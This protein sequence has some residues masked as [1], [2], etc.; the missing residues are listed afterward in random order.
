MNMK[1][2]MAIVAGLL[3]TGCQNIQTRD[4]ANDQQQLGVGTEIKANSALDRSER[5][6]ARIS[7][8][9]HASDQMKMEIP[10]RPEVI[11]YRDWYLKHPKYLNTVTQRAT[12]YLY[13]IMDEIEKRQ[14]PMELVLLPVVESA[15]NPNARSPGNAVGLWQFLSGTGSRFGLKQDR[16][17]DGRRDIQASTSA[18]LD[19]LQII[20]KSLD[21]DWPNTIAAYNAGEKRIQQ[22]VEQ[23]KRRGKDGDFWSLNLPRQTTEYVPRMLALADIIKNADK[24]G[25]KLP[26]FPNRPHLQQIDAGGQVDLAV[27]ADMAGISL[28]EIKQF[29]PGYLRNTTSASG[30][31]GSHLLLVPQKGANELE[32]ALAELPMERRLKPGQ[33]LLLNDELEQSFRLS[34]NRRTKGT[35]ERKLNVASYKVK[36]GDTLWTVSKAHGISKEQLV[37]M[38]NLSHHNLRIGQ[39]LKVPASEKR[40]SG[41]L[42]YQVKRGDSLTSIAQKFQISVAELQR[43][44]GLESRRQLKPGQTLTVKRDNRPGV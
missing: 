15:Y 31:S 37:A 36:R 12:P 34:E 24:Y 21:G 28:G 35:G 33:S 3:L 6:D 22:A 9:Q 43:W 7:V 10:L 29:N 44:N 41:T 27:V 4:D 16:W 11:E 13:L 23:S 42:S 39:E 40:K 19:Y 30:K 5:E 2:R 25:V 20:N 1:L 17:Y 14:M 26:S 18:A 8:W 38:N 32:L